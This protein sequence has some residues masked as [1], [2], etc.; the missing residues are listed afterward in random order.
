[1]VVDDAATAA[2][3]RLVT[4]GTAGCALVVTSRGQLEGLDGAHLIR[5]T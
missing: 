2:Q 4:P 1:V 3:V 5:W